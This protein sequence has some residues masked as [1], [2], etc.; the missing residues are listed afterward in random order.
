M[1]LYLR[2]KARTSTEDKRMVLI[3]GAGDAGELCLRYLQKDK[4]TDYEVAGFIDDEPLK[5]NRRINGVKVLGNRHHLKV[6]KQ[7]YKTQEI[8]LAMHN[9]SKVELLQ[10]L[11][12]CRD[13]QLEAKLF[14]LETISSSQFATEHQSGHADQR[15]AFEIASRLSVVP[16][17]S[18]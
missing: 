2:H 4:H 13:L 18:K 15:P 17:H 11:K 1:K 5:Q 8:F 14:Q 6:L 12:I 3:W 16:D 10:S 9:I 7:L